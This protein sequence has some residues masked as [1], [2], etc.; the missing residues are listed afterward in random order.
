MSEKIKFTTADT[1]K[2]SWNSAHTTATFTHS[3]DCVP[4]VMVLTDE[5]T[6]TF[7]RLSVLSASTFSLEF[8]TE[9]S[10]QPDRPWTC[11]VM[12]GV[13]YGDNPEPSSSS[14]EGSDSESIDNGGY[15]HRWRKPISSEYDSVNTIVNT[16]VIPQI[17]FF[18][19]IQAYYET[20][21]RQRD[22]GYKLS[23]GNWNP[24]FEPEVFLNGSDVQLSPS[25]YS[26]DYNKGIIHPTGFT[27]TPGDNLICSYN[28]S[29]F[30]DDTLE[31]YVHRSIG[32]INYHGQGATTS[33]TAKDL[34][35]SFYGISADLCVAMC[36][37]NLILGQ[38]MWA[39]KLIFA[40]T[41][42]ELYGGGAGSD[43]AS[44]LESMK[45]N[46][47]DRAYSALENEKT[48]APDKVT[49]PT[50]A[51]W[52]AVTLGTGIRPGPHGQ[53]GYGKQRGAK[54]NRMTGMTG[55]DLGI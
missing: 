29:W 14:E 26:I 19:E 5:G 31:S 51:Y 52:R 13:Q 40:I 34:P 41:G 3:L 10:I 53:W 20:A 24:L 30:N 1:E 33:Y 17:W 9:V 16:L 36:C 39:G 21:A 12:Y 42:N 55:P 11:V 6:Q 38:T 45:R 2:V 37:E 4:V 43:V 23:Y 50:P 48:R 7:P 46:S 28:F 22:G 44:Q 32:S 27:P 8:D 25:M 54:Y 49:R 15:I 18:C 47:E 35:E